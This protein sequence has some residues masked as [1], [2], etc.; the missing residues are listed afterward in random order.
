MYAIRSYYASRIGDDGQPDDHA[1]A[2]PPPQRNPHTATDILGSE[3]LALRNAVVEQP[4]Q[5]D[6]V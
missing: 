5:G 4:M 6:F 3:T 2:R 1:D